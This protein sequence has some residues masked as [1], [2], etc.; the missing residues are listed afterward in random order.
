MELGRPAH[1]RPAE[2]GR[3]VCPDHLDVV[4]TF[5]LLLEI[6]RHRRTTAVDVLEAGHVGFG[7]GGIQHHPEH[8]RWDIDAARP[9][10]ADRVD[11]FQ[12]IKLLE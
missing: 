10:A 9:M 5:E 8:S 7:N 12:K 4:D 1:Q 3:A 6:R 11:P 2:L